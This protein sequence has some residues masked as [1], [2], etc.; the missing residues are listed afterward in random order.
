MQKAELIKFEKGLER[1]RYGSFNY[2]SEIE[3]EAQSIKNYT[4]NAPLPNNIYQ[5]RI[6]YCVKELLKG[7]IK[8][9]DSFHMT[10]AKTLANTFDIKL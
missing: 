1:Y 3:K 10:K 7:A 5:R 9:P 8:F 2:T 4:Q 6:S